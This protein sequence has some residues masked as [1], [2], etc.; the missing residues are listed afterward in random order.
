V[1]GDR[2]GPPAVRGRV[3][4]VTALVAVGSAIVY[5]AYSIDPL[6]TG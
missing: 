1:S 4:D 6:S 2:P 5:L 3:F